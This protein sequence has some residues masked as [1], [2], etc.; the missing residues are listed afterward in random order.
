MD[1]ISYFKTSSTADESL[2]GQGSAKAL[3]SQLS[4]TELTASPRSGSAVDTHTVETQPETLEGLSDRFME[5]CDFL[6]SM[7][8]DYDF[9]CEVILL[10]N[11]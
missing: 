1:G 10:L 4:G 7:I 2:G 3:A 6:G 8:P 5:H 11:T 9:R